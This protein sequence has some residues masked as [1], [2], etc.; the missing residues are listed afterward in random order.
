M[1]EN[2]YVLWEKVYVVEGNNVFAYKVKDSTRVE[3]ISMS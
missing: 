3:I 1:R 2:K